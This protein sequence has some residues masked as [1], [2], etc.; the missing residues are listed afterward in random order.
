MEVVLTPRLVRN[1]QEGVCNKRMTKMITP[2]QLFPFFS[3]KLELAQLCQGRCTRKASR[4]AFPHCVGQWSMAINGTSL[5]QKTARTLV[6]LTVYINW[7][8]RPL[9]HWEEFYLHIVISSQ[10]ICK[11]FRITPCCKYMTIYAGRAGREKGC[12]ICFTII[13]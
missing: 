8:L 5:L 12:N 2:H 1:L 6:F 10:V 4:L 11:R 3:A 7:P 13:L 9:H